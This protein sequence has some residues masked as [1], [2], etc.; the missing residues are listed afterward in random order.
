VKTSAVA[1]PSAMVPAPNVLATVGL[2]RFTT[3]HRSLEPLLMP[4]VVTEAARF[5]NA[6]GLPAQ[7]AFTWPTALVRP[8]TVTVQLAVPAAI[9]MPVSPE[10][11][12]VPAV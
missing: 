8:A 4:V 3:R 10:R 11:T 5:V 9:A 7:L 6:A 1:A 12:R 2:T